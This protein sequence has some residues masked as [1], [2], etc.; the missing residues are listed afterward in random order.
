MTTTTYG[1]GSQ[2]LYVCIIYIRSSLIYRQMQWP[3]MRLLILILLSLQ[4]FTEGITKCGQDSRFKVTESSNGDHYEFQL[5]ISRDNC[6]D[7][8]TFVNLN[9]RKKVCSVCKTIPG[10]S[11]QGKTFTTMYKYTTIRWEVFEG[12]NYCQ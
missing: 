1:N 2:T 7:K 11:D 5:C 12:S 4:S 3:I 6:T 10:L 9:D 8:R